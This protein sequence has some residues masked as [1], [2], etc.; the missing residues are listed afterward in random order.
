M[1]PTI[2]TLATCLL[3]GEISLSWHF[4]NVVWD[5]YSLAC[6][7]GIAL[8]GAVLEYNG[9]YGSFA[10]TVRC[11][12][13]T[14][15]IYNLPYHSTSVTKAAPGYDKI[16]L[17][18]SWE[19][20]SVLIEKETWGLGKLQTWQVKVCVQNNL[21]KSCTPAQCIHISEL[22]WRA[23]WPQLE[24][25]L[26]IMRYGGN[27]IHVNG[28]L[29]GASKCSAGETAWGRESSVAHVI[30]WLPYI[31][32]GILYMAIEQVQV[33]L[34]GRQKWLGV[35]LPPWTQLTCWR[36]PPCSTWVRVVRDTP[37]IEITPWFNTVFKYI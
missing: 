12:F 2:V 10:M 37:R 20:W 19:P 23:L 17:I 35:K 32:S 18:N 7:D 1:S 26:L 11:N 29:K 13:W 4:S 28:V 16:D 6:Y 15:I 33:F 14:A 3:N 5:R 9:H 34:L 25:Q 36:K 22:T 24:V 30:K 21:N 27:C 8:N 31:R